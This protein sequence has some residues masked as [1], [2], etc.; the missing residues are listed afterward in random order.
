MLTARGIGS[1]CTAAEDVPLLELPWM[2][3]ATEAAA[4]EEEV[5]PPLLPP[6]SHF[7]LD[8]SMKILWRLP[9]ANEQK[10]TFWRLAING[11]CLS[12]RWAW[13][14]ARWSLHVPVGWQ[15]PPPMRISR[16]GPC[17][18]MS[19][20]LARWQQQ[21]GIQCRRPCR[22]IHK[23][24]AQHYG[25]CGHR[26]GFTAEYG[27]WC[28]QLQLAPWTGDAATSGHYLGTVRRR[29]SSFITPRLLSSPSSLPSVQP[30]HRQ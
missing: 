29:R 17:R 15:P 24:L 13:H 12:D 30:P 11:E 1:M 20:G 3:P 25:C 23:S 19:S 14:R 22:Q 8:A 5:E 9:R 4:V 28:V 2:P 6:A 16:A 18:F 26:G 10:E 27:Q 7:L 21:S